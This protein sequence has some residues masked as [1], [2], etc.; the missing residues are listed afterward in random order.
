M[1][2][3]VKKKIL[4]QNILWLLFG[5]WYPGGGGDGGY[6]LYCPEVDKLLLFFRIKYRFT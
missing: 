6:A 1:K 5:P 4:P 2:N 3:V